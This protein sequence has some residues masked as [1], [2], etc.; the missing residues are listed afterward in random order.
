MLKPRGWQERALEKFFYVSVKDKCFLLDATPGAGKTIFSSFCFK[1]MLDE[2][3]AEFAIIVVPTT[4]L[5]E[6]RE[7][8]FLGDWHKNGVEITT[9]LKDGRDWPSEFRGGVITYQQLPNLIS[10][11]ETWTSAGLRLFTVFDE[12]H[13]ASENNSWGS[14][15]ERLAACSA[16]V[17]AMTG[18]PFRGDGR[19]I[20]FVNY[21]DDGTAKPDYQYNYRTA[22]NERVCRPV[23]FMTDDGVADFV[24]DEIEERIRLSEAEDDGDVRG[25]TNTIFRA[26]SN[27]LR[28]F[29]E[30]AD[31]KLDEYRAADS[32]AGGLIVCRPGNDANDE[33]YLRQIA[34][35]VKEVTG[36]DP[37]VISHDDPDANAKIE[38]FRVG[39]KKWIIAVRKVSEGVDIK[40]L[41]VLV[42]ATRP[43]TELLFRQLVGRVVRVQDRRKVEFSTAYIAKFPQ[44]QEW[45]AKIS[46]EAEQALKQMGPSR[47]GASSDTE[48]QKSEFVALGSKYEGG[49]AISDFGEEYTEAEIN[50]AERLRNEDNR[51]RDFPITTLAY[52]GR[53]FGVAADPEKPAN[54]PLH[55]EKKQLRA[56]LNK[57]VRRVAIKRSPSE[58]DFM[59]VWK[60]IHRHTGAN[61]ID[62]LMDNYNIDVMRQAIVLCQGWLGG[63][64]VF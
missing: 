25:A 7:A 1:Q 16:K 41:R 55:V 58:P 8:G 39:S 57:L 18:T 35:L 63:R 40:R 61:G 43:T 26:D 24:I 3:E 49:G 37:E 64:D 11:I 20:A 48:R 44:L 52:L 54:N 38:R 36:D 46:D 14:S 10:T 5:K 6:D 9:V 33:K 32:D 29:L 22:V 34:R 13:H 15:S 17:L 42:M 53:K 27:W 23:E 2:R 56:E 19:K 21:D 59:Q 60:G 31:A 47:E 45:A 28:T 4:A 30:R 51:L 62:D 12:V 50:A